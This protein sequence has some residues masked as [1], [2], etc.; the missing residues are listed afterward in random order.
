MHDLFKRHPLPW[1]SMENDEGELAAIDN[2]GNPIFDIYIP[3]P[4]EA[5]NL[6]DIVEI[7]NG[8]QDKSIT[9]KTKL[10]EILP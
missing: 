3:W 7:M 6:R 8:L 5:Q 10:I 2:N 4:E 9:C 1:S